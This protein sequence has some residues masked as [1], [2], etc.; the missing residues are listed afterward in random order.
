VIRQS[1]VSEKGRDDLDQI[2]RAV[3]RAVRLIGDLMVFSRQDVLRPEDVPVAKVIGE[4]T[5][6]LPPMLG[7]DLL[8][9]VVSEDHGAYVRVDPPR[10]AHA[11]VNLALN[12]RDAMP[13]G[14]SLT[15]K[16]GCEDVDPTTA[17]RHPGS[18]PGAY[19]AITVSDTGTGMS[20]EVQ[21]RI[22]D[23]F[24][25]TKGVGKGTGL[26]LPMVH[27]FVGQSGGFIDVQTEEGK[28]S[29]FTL[30]LPRIQPAAKA[31]KA[32]KAPK[33]L[34]PE[35]H[36]TILVVEDEK[37]VRNMMARALRGC[38]YTVLEAGKGKE[39]L[40]ILKDKG[41]VALV[42]TDVIMPGMSGSEFAERVRA[43][44]T[45]PSILFVSG[46]AGDDLIQRGMLADQENLLVKPFELDALAG[47]VRRVLDQRGRGPQG[48]A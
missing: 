42:I 26:G 27:G 22:F 1:S 38:G 47:A 20:R 15:V 3:D 34:P 28:G 33:P 4:I 16:T 41:P 7:E 48:P 6:I 13:T 29:A 35:G 8:F 12:A 2:L 37:P 44:D 21:K 46:H 45:A 25:T 31:V 14:G 5:K 9:S 11:I 24:F 18:S 30:H 40:A 43:T 17:K 32:K 10:L 19:V 36:G 23:P 39:A